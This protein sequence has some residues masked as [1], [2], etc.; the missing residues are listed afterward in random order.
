MV[1]YVSGYSLESSVADPSA[2]A[3]RA[4]AMDACHEVLSCPNATTS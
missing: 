1:T 3:D 4:Q 2:L